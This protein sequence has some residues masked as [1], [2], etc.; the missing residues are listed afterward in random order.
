MPTDFD[1]EVR[2]AVV[3]YGGVS[4]AVYINGVAQELLRLV[5]STA[6]LEPGAKLRGSETVYRKLA[7]L[8]ALPAVDPVAGTLTDEDREDQIE[9][10][11]TAENGVVHTADAPQTRFVVDVLSGTSAGGINAVYLAKALSNNQSLGALARMWVTVADIEKL[12]NDSGSVEHPVRR[13]SPP[14]SLLNSRWM[15][16]KLLEALDA[17]DERAPGGS[18][19]GDLDLFSTATDIDGVRC[20]SRWPTNRCSSCGIA[21]FSTSAAGARSRPT[22]LSL[23]NATISCPRTI[24]SWRSP[25]AARPRSRLRSNRWRSATSSTSSGIFPV[26]PASRTA[27][28]TPTSGTTSFSTT[29]GTS[30]GARPPRSVTD[31]LATA[32]IWTT[33]RSVTPSTR[34]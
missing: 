14:K 28:R 30:I 7:C 21:T 13:Q 11:G 1:R 5:R 9:L 15:Y 25:H 10:R 17:M 18:L 2:F 16:L 12:L 24:R 27:T 29:C 26:T 23:R 8:M 31:R 3:I 19:V 34:S 22:P 20:R 32:G 6:T 4:L 33:N